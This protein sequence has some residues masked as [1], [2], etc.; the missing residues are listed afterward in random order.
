MEVKKPIYCSLAFGSV[1]I[2]SYG[3][4]IP[5]CNI[6]TEHY[7]MY[8][9]LPY[10]HSIKHQDPSKRI[11][12]GNLRQIR[13][14]LMNGEWPLACANCKDSEEIGVRSMRTIWNDGLSN[15]NIP[16][17]EYVD[18]KD[19]R[20]LDLTFSTKCNSKCMTCSK[21]L[22]DFWEEEYNKIWRISE[23]QQQKPNRI[24]IDQSTAKKLVNEFPNIE[25]IALIGGE[26]TISEEHVSFLD[27]FITTGRSKNIRLS[28]VTNLTG[29]TEELIEKWRH[30][31][32]VHLSV[33]I[34]GFEKVNEYIRYP[35]KWSKIDSHIKM[36]LSMVKDS[37]EN[38]VDGKTR[39]SIGLSNTVSLFNANQCFDLFDYWFDTLVSFKK[40]NGTLAH[41][42]GCFVNKVT[43]PRYLMVNLLSPEYRELG[44]EK[45]QILLDKIELYKT[46]HP[47]EIVNQGFIDSIKLVMSWLKEPQVINS[48]Y[49]S[50]CKHLITESDQFRNRNIKDYIPDLY[51]ELEKIWK[52]G[53]IPGDF[54]LNGENPIQ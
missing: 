52:I 11:N 18:P 17:S 25:A 10:G 4:Y 46:K 47:G 41:D 26:P 9:D 33:S 36:F 14:E 8:K 23:N 28:Y 48:V 35:F 19:I 30:F 43:H 37:I 2:N 5:C 39:F 1:S 13:K 7:Q 22:S 32:Q 53:I 51:E 40:Q 12:A 3:E 20:Y 15:C 42:I 24:C 54:Y 34:D 21:D 44:I 45:G 29:I 49:L 38:H 16:I 31:G 27:E 6:R 50:Q